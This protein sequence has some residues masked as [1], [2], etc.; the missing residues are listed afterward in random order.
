MSKSLY[1]VLMCLVMAI[2]LPCAVSAE[3]TPQNFVSAGIDRLLLQETNTISYILGPQT[4]YLIYGTTTQ[5]EVE[6]LLTYDDYTPKTVQVAMRDGTIYDLPVTWDISNLKPTT[7][8]EF[9]GYSIDGLIDFTGIPNLVSPPTNN[10]KF[11]LTYWAPYFSDLR[12]VDSMPDLTVPQGTTNEHL[13][14]LLQNIYPQVRVKVQIENSFVRK[15]VPIQWDVTKSDFD[16]EH[17]GPYTVSGNLRLENTGILTDSQNHKAMITVRVQKTSSE[18]LEISSVETA[19]VN[20]YQSY[21]FS[22]ISG[23]PEQVTVTLEDDSAVPVDVEWHPDSYNRDAVGEQMVVGELVNLPSKVKQPD[24]EPFTAKLIVNSAPVD[25]QITA[26]TGDNVF[27]AHAGLTLAEITEQIK[28]ALTVTIKSVTQG[29]NASTQYE[30]GILLEDSKNPDYEPESADVYILSGTLDLPDNITYTGTDPEV[31][32]ETTPVEVESVEPA[33]I[34]AKEGTPFSGLEL[35]ETV[36]ATLSNGKTI[37]LPVDWG[38]GTGYDPS[39]EGLT[40]EHPAEC[41]VTGSVVNWPQ[42]ING[43]GVKAELHI[44]VIKTYTLDAITPSQITM[45]VNLGSSLEDIY[46]LLES[47]TAQLTLKSYQ[48]DT[49]TTNVTF[50]LRDED[51]TAYDPLK[52]GTQTLT[53]YLPLE[54]GVLN[55]NELK[56]E[57]VVQTK[58]YT[59]SNIPAVRIT[60]VVSG[61]PLEEVGLPEQVDVLRNDGVTDKAPV[62]WDGS[63]YN[64]AKIGAQII[65]GT[66]T[67]PLPVHL[68]NPNNRLPNAM[69]TIVD[70]DVTILSMKQVRDEAP[71]ARSLL[72]SAI[73]DKEVLPGFTE[74]KYLVE[75]LHKDGSITTDTLS[76]F[77]EK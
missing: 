45:D 15:M 41:T 68:E 16:G 55:P 76:L 42:Y 65:R 33:A 54:G 36:S 58:K 62:T 8:G 27:T 9:G 77:M 6:T 64:P 12:E 59:I 1:K 60:G 11:Y 2:F 50:S 43:A 10:V 26:V 3:E 47:H 57:I 24:G 21:A 61:T 71:A 51:N 44:T 52:L 74:H 39:P 69:V 13:Q 56:L 22:D 40:D 53:A 30:A 20:A 72:R 7:E 70:P 73:E 66:L 14:S 37:S 17:E 25:Y 49:H 28:P 32:L 67:A 4:Q 31:F 34:L 38:D 29:I 18:Q 46:G 75:L 5:E 35:P 23:L 48:G 19:R 63:K